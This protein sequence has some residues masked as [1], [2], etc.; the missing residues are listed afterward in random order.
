MIMLFLDKVYAKISLAIDL[1]Y[2]GP[3]QIVHQ[4]CSVFSTGW[5]FPFQNKIPEFSMA[6]NQFDLGYKLFG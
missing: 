1:W 5:V 6:W 2:P 3:L 4:K